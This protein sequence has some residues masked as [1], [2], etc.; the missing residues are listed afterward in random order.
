[1]R[2]VTWRAHLSY[3]F[4]NIMARGSVALV[5]L[6]LAVWVSFVAIVTA[7]GVVLRVAPE[8]GSPPALAEAIWLNLAR[9]L[10]PGMIAGDEGWGFRLANLAA[11]LGGIL[12]LSTFIGVVVT[13]IE[14][15]LQRLRQG[16]SL[17]VEHDHTLILGWSPQVFSIAGELAIANENRSRSTVVILADRDKVEMEEAI[18][19]QVPNAGR[20]RIVCRS[21]NPIDMADLEI[22]NPHGAR[23]IVI[24]APVETADPDAHVIKTLLALINNPHRRPEPYHI[25]A[26]LRDASNAEV[27]RMVGRDEVQVVLAGDLIA[28]IAVQTCRQSGL[29]TVYTEL[30]DFRGDEIYFAHEPALAGLSFGEALLRYEDSAVIGLRHA[31]GLV[32]LLPRMDTRIAPKDQIIAVAA[33][34]DRLTLAEGGIPR[35]DETA[36]RPPNGATPGAERTLILGWNRRAPLMIHQL[37]AYVAPGSVVTV[38]TEAPAAAAP[39][40]E[41]RAALQNLGVTVHGGDTVERALLERFMDGSYDHVIVLGDS[42]RLGPQEADARTL[43]TLLH[44]RD[45]VERRRLTCTIV[46]EMLDVRNRELAEVTRADD[47][48]VSD[49]LVSLMLS[50]ISENRDL[51]AV[52]AVLF[53]AA[54]AELYLRPAGEYVALGTPVNFYTVVESARRRQEAAIGYRLKAESGDAARAY[55]VHVNPRKSEVVTFSEGD[56]VIVLAND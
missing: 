10:D 31:N 5:G 25:V 13:G 47:F 18:R 27:A 39:F 53:D 37:E 17:V 32:A 9:T 6:L 48:I 8:G 55:G 22:A 20:T 30:L 15:R 54:G 28:R 14:R 52:F 11:I 44:L 3:A 42:D 24:L 12:L 34:D 35:I 33:D 16:R 45:L 21:G 29:S 2:R 43:I 23:A 7:T 4:D 46:G 1:M 40:A 41:R 51:A 50:Q 38:V 56:R 36:I 26:A 49:R 19:T